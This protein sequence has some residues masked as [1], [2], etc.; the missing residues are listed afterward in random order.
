MNSMMEGFRAVQ[1]PLYQASLE[2][3]IREVQGRGPSEEPPCPHLPKMISAPNP[4]EDQMGTR[5]QV[6]LSTGQHLKC[7]HLQGATVFLQN[8]SLGNVLLAL[9]L[10]CCQPLKS[11]SL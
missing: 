8:V 5:I 2:D 7:L 11:N 10:M 3:G 1:K 6:N 9:P 4:L